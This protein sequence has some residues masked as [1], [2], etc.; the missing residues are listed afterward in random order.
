MRKVERSSIKLVIEDLG[1]HP[2]CPHGPTLLFSLENGE[3][4]FGC[5]FSRDLSD[6]CSFP[7]NFKEFVDGKWKD[8]SSNKVSDKSSSFMSLSEVRKIKF[9]KFLQIEFK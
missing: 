1:L 4:Y 3:K 9:Y 5:S 8:Q 2:K 7:L 6:R